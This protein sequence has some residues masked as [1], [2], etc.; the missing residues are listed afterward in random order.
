METIRVGSKGAAVQK[1]QEI[2]IK[3]GYK[4]TAD[5]SF[6]PQTKAFTMDWQKTKK[7]VPD[8]V[9][10]PAS[11]NEAGV[12]VDSSSL[13]G[14]KIPT[15]SQATDKAAYEIVKKLPGLTEPQRQYLMAVA[16]GEGFFGRGWGNPSSATIKASQA[17]GLTG[18]EGQ[19]SNNWGAVQGKGNAGS[20]QHVDYHA[21]GKPYTAAYKRYAT[22]EDGAADMAR[23]LLKP[24]VKAALDRGSLRDAV[25][26]QHSNRYFELAPEKY[27]SAVLRNYGTLSTNVGWKEI[28]SETGGGIAKVLGSLLLFGGVA[29]FGLFWYM[30]KGQ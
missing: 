13:M 2:L 1:W 7:L 22:P 14:A 4:L 29:A 3:A 19:G 8:G 24:N 5:G 11:W 15:A 10:G 21:D 18:Y 6:G 28:L 16:R 26:A 30:K 25:F 27:L 9:V 17:Y 12:K 23:I 20:F